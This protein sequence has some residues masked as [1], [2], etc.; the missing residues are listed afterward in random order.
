MFKFIFLHKNNITLSIC[1]KTSDGYVLDGWFQYKEYDKVEQDSN[2]YFSFHCV[3][4]CEIP[5]CESKKIT[6]YSTYKEH[7]NLKNYIDEKG[8]IIKASFP[9]EKNKDIRTE[10][11]KYDYYLLKSR[12]NDGKIYFGTDEEIMNYFI[13]KK[14]KFLGKLNS[15]NDVKQI[16]TLQ[17]KLNKVEKN[18]LQIK[19]D[20]IKDLELKNSNLQ[21]AVNDFKAEHSKSVS[22]DNQFKPKY[23]NRS[24]ED[25]YDIIVNIN[26]IKG[27]KYGWKIK[28][29]EIGKKRYDEL[30]NKESLKIGIIGN[31]NKGKSFF[32]QKLSEV[33]LPKGTSIKTEGLSLKYPKFKD[34]NNNIILLDSAGLETPLLKDE[35]IKDK[36]ESPK[37]GNSSTPNS[38]QEKKM[39]FP[40][41]VNDLSTIAKDKALT[42]LFLQNFIMIESDILIAMVGI[43][44]YSEQKLLNR[45][46]ADLKK[47][48]KN[49]SLYVIHNLQTYVEKEQVEK[50][51]NETLLNCATFELKERKDIYIHEK[52]KKMN[53]TYYVEV[54]KEQDTSQKIFHL[55][56]ANDSSNAGNYYNEFTLE[57][58][59][60]RFNDTTQITSFPLVDKIKESFQKMSTEMLENKIEELNF[61]NEEDCIKLMTD[62]D[63]IL[64]RCFVNELG[65]SFLQGNGYEPKYSYFCKDNKMF[66]LVEVPGKSEK[67]SIK[68]KLIQSYY[69]FTITGIKKVDEDKDIKDSTKRFNSREQGNFFLQFPVLVED[70]MLAS[71]KCE[72][73]ERKENGILQFEFRLQES[74]E[75]EGQTFD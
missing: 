29:N 66:I 15:E 74:D 72:K 8:E 44:T 24:A 26:S 32:L 7:G 2:N 20:Q 63:I 12:F 27:I 19:D 55:I 13:K 69:Y 75:I 65:I 58:L 33:E 25:F 37:E 23:D 30:K 43:L 59:R 17:N 71:T 28:Y 68:C 16:K 51:I 6:I 9:E 34:S 50:Y 70:F 61:S 46:K 64:K 10:L 67:I 14:N 36:L 45:I 73:F 49:Y 54:F 22:W 48:K 18:I 31:G 38:E 39:D 56:F 1:K 57:F 52:E 42:E 53:D 11:I 41:M 40:Q 5:I 47:R 60:K 35:N 62:K 4:N 3:S 21:K